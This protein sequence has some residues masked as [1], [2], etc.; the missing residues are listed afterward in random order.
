[1]DCKGV[2][3]I[4]NLRHEQLTESCRRHQL[5]L[6]VWAEDLD[7]TNLHIHAYIAW[8]LDG[9]RPK[10][11]R[12]RFIKNVRQRYGCI[13]CKSSFSGKR[14]PNCQL[15]LKFIW[16]RTIKH[17]GNVKRYIQR[18]IQ[19]IHETGAGATGGQELQRYLNEE[20]SEGLN[21]DSD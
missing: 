8:P 4:T 16:P 9:N 11:R 14:C 1:M 2:H 10:P 3:L 17:R 15:Y 6:Q 20:I 7:G 12:H 13:H 21:E 5:I 19:S 18:K